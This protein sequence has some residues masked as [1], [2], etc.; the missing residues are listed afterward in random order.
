MSRESE[1]AAEESRP[2]EAGE[3]GEK[4]R[5]GRPDRGRPGR[6][7]AGKIRL[8]GTAAATLAV[9]ALVVQNQAPTE[10]RFLY[11][12]MEMPRFAL[13]IFVYLLGMATG[14]LLRRRRAR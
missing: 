10:T 11:W 12:S 9:L 8:A 14:W 1:G 3:A 13:L 5:E 2:P 7:L 4:Q 6:T